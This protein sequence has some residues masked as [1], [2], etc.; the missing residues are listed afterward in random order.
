MLENETGAVENTDAIEPSSEAPNESESAAATSVA[1]PKEEPTPFHEH[2][3]F[4]ELVEQKNSAVAAQKSLEQKLA[5]LEARFNQP[6][7]TPKAPSREESE[8]ES[9]IK[10]LKQVD[11]RL[12]AVLEA[13]AKSARMSEELQKRLE[14]FEKTSA[15]KEQEAVRLNAVAK[16][17]H[18]HET[19]KVSAEVKQFIND[20]LDIMYMQG[21][22]NPQ[23]LE[24]EYKN[25]YD[26]ISKYIDSVKRSERE[27]YVVDKKKDA[28]VPTSQP[29]GKPAQA[30]TKKP[31]FSK[32]K[33][34]ARQEIVSRF[35][36]QHAANRDADAV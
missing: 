31:T 17:N 20:R 27:S 8:F 35:L 29:K 10:D 24:A 26:G 36:K 3:R 33:E 16:V 13:N 9:L 25:A 1:K 11:P 30:P 6:A 14:T 15:E 34:T 23:N 18:L 22:L 28:A 4:K 12:A 19:N 21:K 5:S 7:A 32:D 2:P